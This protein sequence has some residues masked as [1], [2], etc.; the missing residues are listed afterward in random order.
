MR[1]RPILYKLAGLLTSLVSMITGCFGQSTL[2]GQVVDAKSAAPV[3]YATIQLLETSGGATADSAGYFTIPVAASR[4]R[5]QIRTSQ[6]GYKA[7]TR[8]ISGAGNDIRIRLVPD[9]RQLNEVTVR[10][11]R[12]RYRNQ[13]NPAVALIRRVTA[14]R[15]L[16]RRQGALTYQYEKYEKIRLD[17]SNVTPRLLQSSTFRAFPMLAQHLDTS[18]T[19]GTVSLPLYLK[20]VLADV[21]YRQTPKSQKEYVKAE[22]KVGFERYFDGN[23][24]GA[25]LNRLYEEI[26]IYDD[27]ISLLTNQFVSP[28]STLSPAV[29]RFVIIDTTAYDSVR[30]V[31]L[32]F[33]PR[34]RADMA[35]EGT[36]W[37][38]LDSSFA[39]RK[40]SMS[41]PRSINLNFVTGLQIEQEFSRV[42]AKRLML[43]KDEVAINF[44]LLNKEDRVGVLGTRSTIYGR[45]RIDQPID[46]QL[47]KPVPK[48]V[49]QT[50]ALQR[51]DNYWRTVRPVALNNVERGIYAMTD[52]VQNAPIFK[53]VMTVASLVLFGYV[54]RGAYEIGPVNSFYS[55][56]PVEGF[57]LR[58]GGRSL[59]KL[60]PRLYAETFAAYGFR[61]ERWKY[62]GSLTY[63]LNGN[64]I[65]SFP[66]HFL[67]VS[68]QYDTRIPGQEL[69][70][71][72]EDNFLLSFKRGLNN[73]WTYNRAARVEYRQEFAGGFSYELG[74][75]T[76]DQTAAGALRFSDTVGG[77]DLGMVS[78]T[79][80]NVNLRY[81]PNEKF[82]QGKNFRI[83]IINQYPIY[84]L[85]FTAG[86]KGVLGGEY[87]FQTL[88]AR[89][90]KRVFLSPVGF[91]DLT[92]E[93][94]KLWGRV[95]YPL[96]LIHRANQSYSY[97]LESYN[98]MN[99][100]EF[101]SDRYAAVFVDHYFNG[102]LFNKVPLIK[103]LKL[104]EVVTFKGLWGGLGS[105]N[106]PAEGGQQFPLLTSP[107]GQPE[108]FGLGPTPYI[109]M[110]VG[111]ANIF[112]LFRVDLVRR[113][114]YRDNPNV[115]DFG[116]RGRFRF[117]F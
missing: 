12:Q 90:N 54:D 44:N 30:C 89:V 59:A 34:N 29:Y 22:K 113:L 95:P 78:S 67:R 9:S 68:Y 77:A 108:S 47:F 93:G 85:R 46:G 13:D 5:W 55:F 21:Y 23:G 32:G 84:Q 61:D 70:F 3:P 73:R 26:D 6:V 107:D 15:S 25:Y 65:Y 31:R 16:N 62:F 7:D 96:L 19:M 80:L 99:Y 104:R 8:T 102:F 50:D 20:E 24:I 72:Q 91:T 103:R 71:V 74:L 14:N 17:I 117:D 56:N 4:P 87:N 92:F 111:I 112:R 110:S 49:Q 88:T 69:Q 60:N 11:R 63:S 58:V 83:P 42:S 82:F 18:Q 101:V 79:E 52:S 105:E 75:R 48:V 10:T 66:N 39:I 36:L 98:L 43:T 97:Q 76:L 94:G 37:V 33:G 28:V 1:T 41:V 114:T 64:S 53:R 57:R 45:Y 27:N 81:A 115:S 51:S 100:L 35:F 106:N 86:V 116:I 38:A 2:S 40:L 109:E